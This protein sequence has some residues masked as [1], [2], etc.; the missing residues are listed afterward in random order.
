MLMASPA[1]GQ[2]FGRDAYN[3]GLLGPNALPPYTNEPAWIAAS[4]QVS[5]GIAVQR[6]ESVLGADDASLILPFRVEVPF[7]GRASLIIEG[8]PFE[9]W[10]ASA[11]TREK[12]Q[13]STWNGVS[14]ADIRI[15]AKF[16]VFNGARRW[17]SATLRA[18]TKTTTGKSF[19]DHRFINAPGYLFDLLI[20]HRF[21]LP[22]QWAIDVI[23]NGGFLAW[24]QGAFGQND[25]PSFS[26]GARGVRPEFTLT[27]EL[28][29]YWGY[30]NYDKPL[31]LALR[32]DVPISRWLTAYIGVNL[33]L[34]DPVYLDGRIGVTFG[35]PVAPPQRGDLDDGAPNPFV[36]VERPAEDANF[37][38]SK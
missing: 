5:L 32:I 29:T 2:D 19:F 6:T 30:Q 7:F 14:K 8:Q 3:P 38:G 1:L 10:L 27:T 15:G 28:R 9:W 13:P 21:V 17:P 33:G 20:S 24:Q 23:F 25:A 4:P 26:L 11:E 31:L 35:L 37:S 12:W 36:K 16:L 18:M 34:R 22:R